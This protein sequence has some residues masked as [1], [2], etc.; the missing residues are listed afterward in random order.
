MQLTW[1]WC[2]YSDI[3]MLVS[4]AVNSYIS[5]V[6]AGSLGEILLGMT[7]DL[8]ASTGFDLGGYPFP[9]PPILFE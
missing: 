5:H 3:L 7:P 1:M 6:H 8:G 4:I 9:I 2:R